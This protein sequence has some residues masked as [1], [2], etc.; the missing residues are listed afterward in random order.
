M[1]C[2]LVR[3]PSFEI[4]QARVKLSLLETAAIGALAAT[5]NIQ[6][7]LVLGDQMGPALHGQ[8]VLEAFCLIS[9]LEKI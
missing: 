9:R 4:V 6:V 7:Y 8:L 2:F 5:L 3:W 1:L